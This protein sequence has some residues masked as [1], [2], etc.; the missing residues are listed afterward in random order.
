VQEALWAAYARQASE[1]GATVDAAAV[2]A[3]DGSG[4]E[5][6]NGI[7]AMPSMHV[8]MA[9]LFALVGWKTNRG[10]GALLTIY[11][12]LI[13]IGSVHLGWHYAVD[14]YASA[15]AVSSLWL[16]VGRLTDGRK[17]RRR[18]RRRR[19]IGKLLW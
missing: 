3:P 8:A 2:A 17:A 6:L 11:A 10:L 7:S 19:Q 16:V 13:Q 12:I 5:M 4:K 18:L 14:G 15:A 1:T 9:V